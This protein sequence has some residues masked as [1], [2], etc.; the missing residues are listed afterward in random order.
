MDSRE[1][2]V[3]GHIKM[4]LHCQ[5]ITYLVCMSFSMALVRNFSKVCVLQRNVS[6]FSFFHSEAQQATFYI[7]ESF[8]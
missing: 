7:S 1:F 6:E 4:N 5:C 3:F 2:N 8:N